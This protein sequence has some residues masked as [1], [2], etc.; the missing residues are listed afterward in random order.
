MLPAILAKLFDHAGKICGE[1]VTSFRSPGSESHDRDRHP[2][3]GGATTNGWA[4]S[5]PAAD[6]ASTKLGGLGAPAGAG[7]GFRSGFRS[8]E[9]AATIGHLV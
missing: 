6:A 4:V 9:A 3:F 7:R 2:V 1:P 5:F 8:T